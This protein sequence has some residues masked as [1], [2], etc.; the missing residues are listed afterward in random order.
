MEVVAQ[1]WTIETVPVTGPEASAIL[2]R[3]FDDLV[4][5]YYGRPS[6]PEEIEKEMADDGNADLAP[7]RGLFL[8]GRYGG[9]PAGCVGLRLLEPRVAEVKRMFVA[10]ETRGTGGGRFLLTAV[11]EAAAGL[12]ATRM[13]LE[14]REDLTHARSLYTANGY[15]EAAPWAADRPYADRW[16]E[17]HLPDPE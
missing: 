6:R 2:W 14:T 12:G 13:L 11:E 4:A 17:K 10:P 1:H 5:S 16:Y 9:R 3:Y 7:P 15:H 8:L